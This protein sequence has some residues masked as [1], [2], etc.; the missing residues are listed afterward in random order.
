MAAMKAKHEAFRS[1]KQSR[2]ATFANDTF[3]A[4]AFVTPPAG[5]M[6]PANAQKLHVDPMTREL[7]VITSVLTPAQREKLAARIEQGPPARPEAAPAPAN[8]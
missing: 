4:T 7:S 6:D 8:P 3:D 1:E 5:A 2:L